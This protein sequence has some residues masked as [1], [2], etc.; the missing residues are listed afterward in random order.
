MA[1]WW[2]GLALMLTRLHP[3]NWSFWIIRP[4]FPLA[5]FVAVV[6]LGVAWAY[7]LRRNYLWQQRAQKPEVVG[8]SPTS[9]YIDIPDRPYDARPA[10]QRNV[11][12]T[13]FE[14]PRSSLRA[15]RLLLW[16]GEGKWARGI[17]LEIDGH[18]PVEFCHSRR[19]KE[20]HDVYAA[21]I[22]S[23]AATGGFPAGPS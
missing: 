4:P 6:V 7:A 2:I 12:Q 13:P 15:I 3:W 20:I 10:T 16:Q 17:I 5:L 22:E 19:E 8:I 18:E 9:I 23:A 11:I 21:L 14:A 1:V